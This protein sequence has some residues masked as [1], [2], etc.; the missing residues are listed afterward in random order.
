[1][2]LNPLPTDEVMKSWNSIADA[3]NY[4]KVTKAEWSKVAAELG[5]EGFDEIAMLVGVSDDDDVVARDASGLTPLRKGAV[6][7]LFGS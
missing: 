5:D 1:M 7:L 3:C 4:Y 2:A 6:N